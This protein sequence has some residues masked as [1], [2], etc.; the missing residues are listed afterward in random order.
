MNYPLLKKSLDLEAAISWLPIDSVDDFYPDPVGWQDIRQ[1]PGEFISRRQHRIL[2][3]DALPHI[4]E[5]VPKK[6][7]MLR[8]AVWLHPCHRILYLAVLHR[9]LPRLDSQLSAAVFS[10]RVDHPDDPN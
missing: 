6:S 9:L 7:G 5:Y 8:E 4:T 3:A 2:Q 10:Y 1:Y